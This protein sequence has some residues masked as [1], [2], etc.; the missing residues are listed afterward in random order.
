VHLV[1]KIWCHLGGPIKFHICDQ[2]YASHLFFICPHNN[3]HNVLCR[4]TWQ[5]IGYVIE[6][7]V[8]MKYN[9]PRGCWGSERIC[10]IWT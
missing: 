3:L 1:L 7:C 4:L 6:M 9:H 5:Q 10:A 2:F 8:P